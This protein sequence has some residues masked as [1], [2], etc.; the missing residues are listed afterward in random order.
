[1]KEML[2]SITI[3]VGSTSPGLQEDSLKQSARCMPA[4]T[5]FHPTGTGNSIVPYIFKRVGA[6]FWFLQEI[7]GKNKNV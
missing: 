1:M 2:F 4:F 5:A 7:R 6:F 3:K